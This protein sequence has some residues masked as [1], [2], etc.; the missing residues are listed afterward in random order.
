MFI[1]I[2]NVMYTPHLLLESSTL[3]FASE[4]PRSGLEFSSAQFAVS[5]VARNLTPAV[6]K[7]LINPARQVSSS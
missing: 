3:V 2:F 1:E 5:L 4:V 6:D 7:G